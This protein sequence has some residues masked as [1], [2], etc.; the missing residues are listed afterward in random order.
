MA[1]TDVSSG[2]LALSDNISVLDGSRAALAKG[3]GL[4]ISN[5]GRLRIDES[6][7]PLPIGKIGLAADDDARVLDEDLVHVL[8]G[9]ARCLRVEAEDDGEPGPA[10]D[11]KDYCHWSDDVGCGGYHRQRLTQVES[12]LEVIDA[13]L[14]ELGNRKAT[15][16]V[17][18]S[19]RSSSPGPPRERVDFRVV[20][21]GD[22]CKG[23]AVEPGLLLDMLSKPPK[24]ENDLP[25]VHEE[26]GRGH[27][28]ELQIR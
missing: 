15:D 25:V 9:A 8:E 16:P 21:P 18:C 14:G 7:G 23:R 3:R 24:K 4:G 12:P 22:L 1:K 27:L 11:S 5:S 17:G 19:C 28:A 20:D 26:H 13:L 10:E 2:I 6:L